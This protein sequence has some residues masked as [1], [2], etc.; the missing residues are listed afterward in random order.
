MCGSYPAGVI[1]DRFG[2]WPV[3]A[4]GW[5]L[6][7]GVYLGLARSGATAIWPLLAVYGVYLALTD[8]VGKALLADH[9]PR[10]RRGLAMGIFYMAT[11]GMTL[12]SSVIA[13]VLW[14][15]V[16][17][18][19]PFYFAGVTS[20]LAVILLV[21]IRPWRTVNENPAGT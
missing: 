21:V 20:A 16:G 18:E 9:A 17:P 1:S 19:A 13:G 6:Y 8:G 2:R 14:D 15:R 7:A 12:V 3:I 4:A 11:G 5:I 10:D